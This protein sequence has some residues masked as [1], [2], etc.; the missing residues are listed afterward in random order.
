MCDAARMNTS[1]L[2]SCVVNVSWCQALS[3]YWV[4]SPAAPVCTAH[5]PPMYTN[6][7]SSSYGH[8]YTLEYT[9]FQCPVAQPVAEY[10]P[11]S[12][13]GAV[14]IATLSEAVGIATLS[15][16]VGIAKLSEASRHSST[17]SRQA[18][19]LKPVQ[20]RT[21]RYSRFSIAVMTTLLI[22]HPP[23]PFVELDLA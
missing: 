8:L 3:T 7:P 4:P 17:R 23:L 2:L 14:G 18:P 9:T 22:W 11:H 1:L 16:A 10:L 6:Y 15:G 13:S 5:W 12:L 19:V 21:K 20:C